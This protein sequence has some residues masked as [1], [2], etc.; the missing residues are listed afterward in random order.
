MFP[1]VSFFYSRGYNVCTYMTTSQLSLLFTCLL[2]VDKLVHV[3]IT[4]ISRFVL[5]KSYNT[6]NYNTKS[7]CVNLH[8]CRNSS[9][10]HELVGAALQNFPINDNNEGDL[11]IVFI[12]LNGFIW[13]YV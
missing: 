6:K 12:G 13:M 5:L 4:L 1:K 2:L 11:C 9:G 7:P 8:T 3:N 10:N